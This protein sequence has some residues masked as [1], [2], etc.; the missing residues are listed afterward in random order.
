MGWRTDDTLNPAV[1]ATVRL[2]WGKLTARAIATKAGV[3]EA[4]VYRIAERFSLGPSGLNRAELGSKAQERAK[5]SLPDRPKGYTA[6]QLAWAEEHRSHPEARLMLGHQRDY[7]HWL[8][9]RD[10]NGNGRGR[11]A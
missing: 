4:T 1:I 7:L 8:E 3:S 9:T 5:A 2:H 6:A 11:A 10:E